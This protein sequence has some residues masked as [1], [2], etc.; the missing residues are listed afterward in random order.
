MVTPKTTHGF[1]GKVRGFFQTQTT[2]ERHRSGVAHSTLWLRS[3]DA[4]KAAQVD[5]IGAILRTPTSAF[6][7][8]ACRKKIVH[9][10]ASC[11]FL[12]NLHTNNFR[13]WKDPE[14][15]SP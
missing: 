9:P 13:A 1:L 3:L 5:S 15:T 8:M 4:Q 11:E 2:P 12:E 7:P 14:R 6:C 10:R